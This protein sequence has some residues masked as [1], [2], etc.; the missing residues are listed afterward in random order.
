MYSSYLA[1]LGILFKERP[2]AVAKFTENMEFYVC[3]DKEDFAD[4]AVGKAQSDSANPWYLSGKEIGE[5]KALQ[6]C[7]RLD[8]D[9]PTGLDCNRN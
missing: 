4:T 1:S 2:G 7:G 3:S 6:N 8:G 9:S 5:Q